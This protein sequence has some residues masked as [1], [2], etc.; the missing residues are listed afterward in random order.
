M[1]RMR[2]SWESRKIREAD[3]VQNVTSDPCQ[4]FVKTAGVVSTFVLAWYHSSLFF[5]FKVVVFLQ[6]QEKLCVS[7]DCLQ[8]HWIWF[9]LKRSLPS[10]S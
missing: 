6:A 8:H 3:V 5:F 1:Q 7:S 2:Q 9:S 10:A 4:A